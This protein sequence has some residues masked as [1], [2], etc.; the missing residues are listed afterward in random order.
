MKIL[1]VDTERGF[2]GGEQQL[3]YLLEGLK[4]LGVEQAVV[5]RKNDELEKSTKALGIKTYPLEG[6]FFKSVKFL[7]QISSNYDLVHA[8]AAKAHTLAVF[9][10]VLSRKPLIYT[11]RV[12][13]PPRTLLSWIKYK[14]TTRTIA[15]S[16][17]VKRVL[18]DA[19]PL[20]REEDIK[21]I[22]SVVDAL[23]LRESVDSEKVREIKAKLGGSPLIGTLSALT[24][25]KDIPNFINAA[26]I[27]SRKLPEAKFVVFGEG[28][29]RAKLEKLIRDKGLSG[30]FILFGFVKDVA[31][32]T[33]ALDI[34]VLSSKAEGLPGSLL[35]AMSLG[36]P[37]VST[38]VGGASE[39][40]NSG[41]NGI[42]VPPQNPEALAHA[43]LT[44]WGSKKLAAKFSQNAL[45]TVL[46]LFTPEVM[47]NSYLEIYREVL[48]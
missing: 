43:V 39:V 10:K 23:K 41:K 32:Y 45:K 2:R 48:R 40:I 19:L 21:V 25:Q 36:I 47:V 12:N 16:E 26:Q 18:L 13:F 37:C 46:D 33:K 28:K 38:D 9:A 29:D 31:N 42:L 14:M 20:T 1:H 3:I 35:V 34:F 11:R 30:K 17:A 7:S 5:C 6:S 24:E 44:L 22:H 8:H 15:V 27:I 4:K